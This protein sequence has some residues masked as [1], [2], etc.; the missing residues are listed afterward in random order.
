MRQSAPRRRLGSADPNRDRLT[1]TRRRALAAVMMDRLVPPID[2]LP[3][4]GTMGLLGG[5]RRYSARAIYRADPARP[6]GGARH[7]G[8]LR[9][10]RRRADAAIGRFETADLRSSRARSGPWCTSPYYGN[11]QVQPPHRLA[12]RAATAMGV[13]LPPFDEL[14]LG[15][16]ASGRLLAVG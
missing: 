6:V 3:G 8:V 4:A 16:P 2:D 13:H 11:R 7:G 10:R 1:E 14:V 15:L 12:R 9:P 5:S